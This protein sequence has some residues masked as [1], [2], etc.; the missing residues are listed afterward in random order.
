KFMPRFDGPYEILHANP[1]K[2]SYTLNM[3]NTDKFFP[4][5]HSSHLRP[6]IAND[7]NLFPSRKLERPAP[8]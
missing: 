2:S 5:F 3:P 4:T 1:E 7:S 8:V 6:F